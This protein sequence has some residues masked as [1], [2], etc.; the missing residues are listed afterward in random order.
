MDNWPGTE[1][2]MAETALLYPALILT[3]AASAMI[4]VTALRRALARTDG[5][6]A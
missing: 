6:K 5:R 2:P 4:L 1:E 3:G